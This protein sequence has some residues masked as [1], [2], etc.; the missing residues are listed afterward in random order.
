MD[1][2]SLRDLVTAIRDGRLSGEQAREVLRSA[3]SRYARPPLG[4]VPFGQDDIEEYLEWSDRADALAAEMRDIM[5]SVET[6]A[7]Q[8]PEL[9]EPVGDLDPGSEILL[10]FRTHLPDAYT[11]ATD[12]IKVMAT[13]GTTSFRWL[14]L[15]SLDT[16][17][18][19]AMRARGWPKDALERILASLVHEPRTRDLDPAAYPSKAWTTAQV[20]IRIS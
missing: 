15:P 18:P 4:L 5:S 12:V 3:A 14:E 10:P 8:S 7:Q 11:A 17:V 16:D 19:P 1:D 13:V 2:I 9:L 6:L 20:Q